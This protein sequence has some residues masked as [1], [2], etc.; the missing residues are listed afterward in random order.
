MIEMPML[1]QLL[2]SAGTPVVVFDVSKAEDYSPST[3]MKKLARRLRACTF[4]ASTRSWGVLFRFSACT[5]L[6]T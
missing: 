3:G 1:V 4:G 6:L 2:Q 5:G